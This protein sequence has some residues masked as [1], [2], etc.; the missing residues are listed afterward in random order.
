M[1]LRKVAINGFGH[2]SYKPLD[3]ESR[4]HLNAS[5]EELNDT[6]LKLSPT[7]LYHRILNNTK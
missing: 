6:I 5:I 7:A 3:E 1:G 4:K 2:V